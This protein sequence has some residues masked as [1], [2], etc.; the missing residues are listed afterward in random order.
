[1]TAPEPLD[2]LLEEERRLILGA[3]WTGIEAL[4]PRK[5]RAIED[6]AAEGPGRIAPFAGRIARNQ[7]LLGAALDGLREALRRRA[8]LDAARAGLVT[9]DARGTRAEVAPPR[10]R[11]ERKA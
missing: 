4:A 2:A 8:A 7:R 11:L 5:A 9:Y 6:A 10:S 1:M 3:D